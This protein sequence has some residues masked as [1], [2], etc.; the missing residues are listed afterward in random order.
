MRKKGSFAYNF[1]L[2]GDKWFIFGG[3]KLGDNK[4]RFPT[5]ISL[6]IGLLADCRARKIIKCLLF[7]TPLFYTINSNTLPR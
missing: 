6:Y 3:D 5:S 7:A 4:K 2:A 1:D